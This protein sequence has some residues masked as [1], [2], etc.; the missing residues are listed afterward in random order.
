M[1]CSCYLSSAL[2]QTKSIGSLCITNLKDIY[3][4]YNGCKWVVKFVVFF[5]EL[6]QCVFQFNELMNSLD[7]NVIVS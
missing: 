4:L 1:V 7:L 2:F 6:N 3:F 5:V